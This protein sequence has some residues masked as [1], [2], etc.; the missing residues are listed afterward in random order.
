M[1]FLS[2]V[3]QHSE[4]NKMGIPNLATVFGPNLLVSPDRSMITMVQDTP[5]INGI[6]NTLI[7]DFDHIFLVSIG[8]LVLP[9]P[10]AETFCS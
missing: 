3:K 4:V 2:K 9:A 1:E 7:Q 6:V 10:T 8:T 5:Q